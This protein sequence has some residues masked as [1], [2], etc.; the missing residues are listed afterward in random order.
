M[1]FELN[2]DEQR[3]LDYYKQD[4]SRIFNSVCASDDVKERFE[5][6]LIKIIKGYPINVCQ[7]DD[8]GTSESAFAK[9]LKNVDDKLFWK[10]YVTP[11]VVQN[12]PQKY[13]F[14]SPLFRDKDTLDWIV[15]KVKEVQSTSNHFCGLSCSLGDLKMNGNGITGG[16]NLSCLFLVDYE[17]N[18]R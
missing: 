10:A 18:G 14:V 16:T 15:C 12:N 9:P 1:D 6:D 17:N 8:R 7:F 3:Q 2:E 13:D 5:T 11:E 4:W